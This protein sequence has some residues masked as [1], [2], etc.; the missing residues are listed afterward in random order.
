MLNKTTVFFLGIVLLGM[1]LSLQGETI[2][3]QNIKPPFNLKSVIE[4]VTHHPVRDGD[5][6]IIRDRVYEAI[7]KEGEVVLRAR[8]KSPEAEDVVIPVAGIPEIEGNKVVYEYWNGQRV[9]FEGKDMGLR[10]REINPAHHPGQ[11]GEHSGNIAELKER[12]TDGERSGEFLIDTSVVYTGA[13]YSQTYPAIAFDGTNYLVVWTDGRSGSQDIYGVR[14]DTSGTVLDPSGILISTADDDQRCPSIAFDGTNYLV[15]WTDERS[16]SADIYGARVTPSGDVLDTAG[17]PISTATDW[18]YS[19]SIAF[20]GTNYLVV[21]EDYRNGSDYDIYG[22]RVDTSG[23]V[24]DPSGILISPAD[25]DQRCPS[26]A[27]DGINYL[28]AW[29]DYRSYFGCDIYGARVSP[30]GTVLEPLG[31]PVSVADDEQLYPSI[32]FDGTNYLVVWEDWRSGS[33]IYGA[34][35]TSSGRVLDISGIPISTAGYAQYWPSIAFDGTNYLVVWEDYRNGL[36]DIYGAWV[37][38]SGSVIDSFPVSTQS[39]IQHSPEI[40]KG[41]GNQ[42]LVVYSGWTDSINGHPVNTMRIWGKF[43]Q[44]TGIEEKHN[45]DL[46]KLSIYPNPFTTF[47]TICYS[48]STRG[49]VSMK[50]YDLSGR[51]VKTLVNGEQEQGYYT[52]RWDGTDNRGERLSSGIYFINFNAGKLNQTKKVILTK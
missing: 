15:V 28:V 39:G 4:K 41:T 3:S 35:V 22:A 8:D 26:I 7:F 10:F 52:I 51:V 13:A 43:L 40:A 5:R 20:D 30:S 6:I 38:T 33:D 36:P 48:I 37:D 29:L 50:I 49:G 32:A 11:M 16:G 23:T 1:G 34:R 17:I 18:Q 25:D 9:I 19:P 42:M 12:Y 46:M 44:F 14:V 24:L 31:I 27:F 21:W 2:S 47:T 45:P